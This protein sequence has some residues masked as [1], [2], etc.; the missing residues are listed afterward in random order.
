MNKQGR[1][2][3]PLGARHAATVRHVRVR[4]G[5]AP[6]C[7]TLGERLLELSR[8][9]EIDEI[10]A[11]DEVRE[12]SGWLD[13]GCAGL[14]Q[15]FEQAAADSDEARRLRVARR[16]GDAKHLRIAAAELLR[17]AALC[18]MESERAGGAVRVRARVDGGWVVWCWSCGRLASTIE[19]ERGQLDAGARACCA[20]A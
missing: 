2:W 9:V 8:E 14:R 1:D 17:A 20:G 18:V 6:W 16:S 4:E 12:I 11:A 7:W 5:R 3:L 10:G 19:D 15:V 13:A